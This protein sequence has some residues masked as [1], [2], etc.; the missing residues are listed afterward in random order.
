MSVSGNQT[1]N[2]PSLKTLRGAL[3]LTLALLAPVAMSATIQLYETGPAEDA[4]FVRFVNGGEQ[5]MGVSA[6]G[7]QG[8][9]EVDA[10][11]PVSAFMPVRGGARMQGRLESAR[12]G[13]DLDVTVQPGE[14]ASVVG[15]PGK[16][17]LQTVVVREQPDDFNAAKVSIAFYNLDAGCADAGLVA[18]PRNL[19]L[20]ERV[21]QGQAARRLVNPVALNVSASCGGQVLPQ[22]L[23]LGTLQAGDRHTVFLLPSAQGPRL[24]H[25]ED[26]VGR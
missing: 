10:A 6:K 23:E 26:R 25:A 2:T 19:A 5:P 11:E 4:A 1:M 22:V 14:F 21:P 13:Q 18:A 24:L 15:L 16:D 7:S 9:I 8:R 3:G 12:Q 20:F 17:G